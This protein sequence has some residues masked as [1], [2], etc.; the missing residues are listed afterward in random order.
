MARS[1]DSSAWHHGLVSLEQPGARNSDSIMK[2]LDFKTLHL[3][4]NYKYIKIMKRS[5][6]KTKFCAN[7]TTRIGK[8]CHHPL[9]GSTRL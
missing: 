6:T 4:V 9:G 5:L 3:N 1:L 2:P 8:G 7:N